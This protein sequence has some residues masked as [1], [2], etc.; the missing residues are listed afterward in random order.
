MRRSKSSGGERR[1]EIESTETLYRDG[2]QK[3]STNWVNLLDNQIR[4]F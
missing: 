3:L 1:A 2:V 4:Q